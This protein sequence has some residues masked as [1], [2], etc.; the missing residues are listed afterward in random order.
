MKTPTKIHSNIFVISCC[1]VYVFMVW[2]SYTYKMNPYLWFDEAGQFWISK[3]LNHD[4]PLLSPVGGLWDVIV[5]NR[6]YNLD[7]GGFSIL[8]FFW[9]KLSNHFIWLRTLP[10]VL[11][12]LTI[13]S[14]I[15]LVY[16]WIKNKYISLLLGFVPLLMPILYN[17]AFELRAYSMEILGCV[18]GVIVLDD[19]QKNLSFKMLFR[20]SLLLSAFMTARYSF[21]IVAFA[22]SIYVL[23]LIY[24][25]NEIVNNKKIEMVV[26]YILP[27][28]LTLS[29]IYYFSLRFQNPQ[30]STLHYLPYLNNDISILA[31]NASLLHLSSI[32]FIGWLYHELKTF[33]IVEKYKGVVLI[34]L[35]VNLLF[36][37]LS[38]FGFHPWGGDCTRCISMITLVAISY[39]AI[40][41][42][43]FKLINNYIDIKFII[44]FVVCITFLLLYKFEVR[45]AKNR[46]NSLTNYQLVDVQGRVYVDRWE[47]PCMRYQLEYGQLSDRVDNIDQFTFTSFIPHRLS[48]VESNDRI[49]ITDFYRT[50]PH[51]NELESYDVLIIPELYIYRSDEMESWKSISSKNCVWIRK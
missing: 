38:L 37:I 13:M 20:C 44:L 50:Q 8:L 45:N 4:S 5:N 51:I 47:S 14:W 41:A 32:I 19:L 31:K 30:I 11:F 27:L 28:L 10:F 12:L 3:G 16:Q 22:I 18:V 17:E 42:E 9:S 26:V 24:E 46:D 15:Y 7:P 43:V 23:Y 36:I 39:T 49:T 2:F 6:D 29:A 33:Q 1:I 48:L 40:F 35:I 34:T 21:I 25:S